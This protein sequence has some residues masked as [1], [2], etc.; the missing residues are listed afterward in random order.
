MNENM[1]FANFFAEVIKDLPLKAV[2]LDGGA[3]IN[4]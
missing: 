1:L 4:A 2:E 3:E